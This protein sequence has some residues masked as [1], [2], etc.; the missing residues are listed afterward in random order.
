VNPI[1]LRRAAWL[2]SFVLAAPLFPQSPPA[3]QPATQ[4][5]QENR[6]AAARDLLVTV[7]KS[8]VIDS[9]VDI[10]RVSVANGDIAEAVVVNP[11]EVLVN[12]KAAGETS[13]IVWQRGG[14]RLFFDLTVRPNATIAQAPAERAKGELRR[15][16]P[17]QDVNLTFENNTVFLQGTVRDLT[18][19]DRAVSIASTLGKVVNLLYV[20]VPP[21]EVQVL[22]KVRFASV[23]RSVSTQWGVN[24]LSTGATNTIGRTSTGQFTPPVLAVD[25]DQ[26][27]ITLTDA[28]NV[29]LFRRDLNL[30]ATIKALQQQ[31]LAEILAEPNL[32]AMNGKP[33]SFL[34]GG[35]FP[36]PTLQGG[37]AGLG[38][39]TIQFRE[40]GVR[41]TFLPKVT[42]RGT[43]NLQVTPEV[44]ALDYAN[45]LTFQ[46][47]VIPGLTTRRV[48]TEIELDAGQSFVIGGLLDN[49]MTENLSKVPGLGDI[50]VLGKLFQ[51]KSLQRNN[52]ELL[53]LVTPELVRPIPA[54]QKTPEIVM[55]RTDFIDAGAK[56][57]RTPGMTETGPVPVKP[58]ND[59]IPVE[60]LVKSLKPPP[61]T[62]QQ[63]QPPVQFVPVPLIPVQPGAAGE[64]PAR[65]DS[66]PPSAEK[67][68][69][70]EY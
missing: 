66:A 40:F 46:G 16:L 53:V 61:Q 25:P 39:V 13:F 26:T 55:P 69:K 56:P 9:P 38:A 34:A 3:D 65:T 52:T 11:R 62:G 50:P 24:L 1:S 57:P 58:P 49:R 23:D 31:N 29:F 4:P 30:G 6:G 44:S 45:G 20:A 48:Q 42:P 51:S 22:L 21:T 67:P 32:L 64:T 70:T 2:F 33:A 54:G 10:A 15:Y 68:A 47:F 63:A 37:G 41:L 59:T 8:V 35:E 5:A 27:K 28:L 60:D 7:G 12:G 43:I 36:Y 19:A 18:S 14:D 17:G